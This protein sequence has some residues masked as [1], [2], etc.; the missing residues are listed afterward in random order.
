MVRRP[1]SLC[2]FLL[3]SPAIATGS[4]DFVLRALPCRSDA[5]IN[6]VCK[7]PRCSPADTDCGMGSIACG[8]LRSGKRLY[9]AVQAVLLVCQSRI[10]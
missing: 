6:V 5:D 4:A 9:V 8:V 3:L 1:V 10:S 7:H 2:P